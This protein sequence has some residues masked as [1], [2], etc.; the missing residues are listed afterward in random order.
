[1]AA[2]ILTRLLGSLLQGVEATDPL[3]FGATAVVLAGVAVLASWVP[4][5]RAV[6]V[7]PAQTLRAD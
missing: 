4:A 2:G 1:V 6:Q 5:Q 7:D 3:T